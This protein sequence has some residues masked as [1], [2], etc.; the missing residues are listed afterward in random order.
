MPG[1]YRPR[2]EQKILGNEVKLQENPLPGFEVLGLIKK[3]DEHSLFLTP[4]LFMWTEYEQK[5]QFMKW[6]DR[7]PNLAR[8]VLLALSILLSLVLLILRFSQN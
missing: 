3:I 2:A 6:I 7:N 4:K 8:D 1:Y 5:N